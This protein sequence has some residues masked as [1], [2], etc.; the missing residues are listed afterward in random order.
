[1]L[2]FYGLSCRS[3]YIGFRDEG[4]RVE[5]LGVGVVGVF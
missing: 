3:V 5:G 1:M 2:G 4:S